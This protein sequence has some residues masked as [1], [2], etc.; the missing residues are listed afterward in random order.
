MITE[1]QK[2]EIIS[3]NSILVNNKLGVIG[4]IL[5]KRNKDND[6]NIIIQGLFSTHNYIE[7]I[8]SIESNRYIIKGIDVMEEI[9]STND[10]RIAYKFKAKELIIKGESSQYDSKELLKLEI[11]RWEKLYGG[12]TEQ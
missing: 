3:D 5:I 12:G 6:N 4:D 2:K 7:E 11:E 8:N 1:K 9:F 10:I